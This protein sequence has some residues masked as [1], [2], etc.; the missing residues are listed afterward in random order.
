MGQAFHIREHL[1]FSH[2][3]NGTTSLAQAICL[4]N[5]LQAEHNCPPDT[6]AIEWNPQT[7]ALHL[8]GGLYMYWLRRRTSEACSGALIAATVGR[9]V[10]KARWGIFKCCLSPLWAPRPP[11]I[12]QM[13]TCCD[14]ATSICLRWTETEE[15]RQQVPPVLLSLKLPHVLLS[16]RMRGSSA[17][18]HKEGWH[19]AL[20]R[21]TARC[22]VHK[23]LT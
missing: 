19:V 1:R 12:L 21:A 5:R 16:I 18:K 20:S 22:S 3:Q 13:G 11:L 10:S 17:V 7:A 4:N 2:L 14:A 15:A 9:S 23:A 6:V 8:V